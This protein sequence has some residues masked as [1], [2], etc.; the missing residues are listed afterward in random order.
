M[1]RLTERERGR[2]GGYEIGSA[3]Q[4]TLMPPPLRCEACGCQ[5]AH[6]TDAPQGVDMSAA[7]TARARHRGEKVGR[8][9]SVGRS[10]VYELIACG[11]LASVKLGAS[12]RVTIKS[13]RKLVAG[14]R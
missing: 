13:I 4:R 14:A 10:R 7:H 5:P 2:S 12:R 1:R 9:L 11:D 6:T 3:R 8:M